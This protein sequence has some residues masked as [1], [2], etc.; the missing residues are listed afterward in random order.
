MELLRFGA[1]YYCPVTPAPSNRML[2][3]ISQDQLNAI[4]EL[5]QK[6]IRVSRWLL[7]YVMLQLG[8]LQLPVFWLCAAWNRA[9]RATDGC[10]IFS[11][12]YLI[13]KDNQRR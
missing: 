1:V 12:L 2:P 7:L 6:A 11:R 5:R 10:K 13:D 3:T 9:R 4:N 8:M